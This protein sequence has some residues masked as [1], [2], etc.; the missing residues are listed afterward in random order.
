MWYKI[1]MGS[2]IQGVV[3]MNGNEHNQPFTH[4]AD[5][6]GAKANFDINQ[7]Q[8]HTRGVPG[9]WRQISNLLIMVA[10]IAVV[11]ILVRVFW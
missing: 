1:P 9:L 6:H 2:V 11:V 5:P 7:Q 3:G 10:I 4:L 8:L